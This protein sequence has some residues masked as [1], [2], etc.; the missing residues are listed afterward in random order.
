MFY[1]HFFAS[2]DGAEGLACTDL[3]ARTLIGA[4]GNL[5]ITCMLNVWISG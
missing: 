5:H 3:G 2:V 4:S 1:R